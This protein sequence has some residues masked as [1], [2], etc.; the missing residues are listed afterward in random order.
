[1]LAIIITI[2]I[3]TII[4]TKFKGQSMNINMIVTEQEKNDVSRS[5]PRKTDMRIMKTE[6][7]NKQKNYNVMGY[8]TQDYSKLKVSVTF[9]RFPLWGQNIANWTFT[10]RASLLIQFHPKL[11]IEEI[12]IKNCALHE[13]QP[14]K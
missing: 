7:E 4:I 13:L 11:R 12:R 5:W 6:I 9:L 14:E 8:T 2:I 10:S 1:M 3:I